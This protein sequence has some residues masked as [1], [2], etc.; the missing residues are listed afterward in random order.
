MKDLGKTFS[1]VSSCAFYTEEK[2]IIA[3][4]NHMLNSWLMLAILPPLA[5]LHPISNLFPLSPKET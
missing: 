1:T 3:N 2:E 5:E 4:V